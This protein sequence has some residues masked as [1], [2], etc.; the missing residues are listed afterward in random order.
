MWSVNVF[1]SVPFVD[2]LAVTYSPGRRAEIA[3]YAVEGHEFQ[4]LRIEGRKPIT[5]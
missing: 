5:S 3:R 4:L 1:S 2:T